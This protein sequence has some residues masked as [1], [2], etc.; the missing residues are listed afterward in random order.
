MLNADRLQKL[1][2]VLFSA[3]ID[4]IYIGPSTDL[5]YLAELQLFDDQRTKGLVFTRE[6]KT[7]GLVPLLYEQEMR[8]AF[9][10]DV[11][12]MVWS[13][14]EGFRGA[15]AKGC[16]ELGLRGKRIAINDGVRATD[17][18]DMR[19]TVEADYVNGAY[20]L[21]PLRRV[22]DVEELNLMRKASEIADRVIEDISKFLRPGM[23]EREVKQ[24][25]LRRFIELGAEGPS[26]SPIVASGP[27]GSM[28]HYR[29][30]DRA[31]TEGDFVV[32]DMG[33]R[34]RGYCSDITRTFCIGEPDEEQ[35]KIY[36]VVLAAQKTGEAAVKAGATGQDVD[37]AA[38]KVIVD[39]GYGP[40]FL[41][42][43]GHGIGIALHEHP[44]IIEGNDV[45]LA[46]GNVF[47]IEPGI[48]LPEKYGV[49]IENLVAV[50]PDGT[51]EALNKFT[52][53]LIVVK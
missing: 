28:P 2:S 39:A 38:R 44:Y 15:F 24:F 21:S 12:C 49:R 51:G 36:G 27:G 40:N 14:H 17:L 11:P 29:K 42:R 48:Y 50:R 9:G 30:E 23:V 20:T 5:E 26:F 16:D 43:L 25:L 8:R 18:I 34:Y 47:S 41:N 6:C 7:F 37:R 10:P 45:P 13:D 32:I 19:L 31:L 3:G 52:R 4:A 46:P 33:C 53:D 35:K 1:A 22:K